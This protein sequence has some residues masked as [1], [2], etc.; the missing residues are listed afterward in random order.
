MIAIK[1]LWWPDDV[2]DKWRHAL[3]HLESIEVGLAHCSAR[4]TAVQ[5]G[6]NIGL[7]P[8]RLSE[9]F[10]RVWTF[11]PDDTSRACLQSNVPAN[12]TVSAQALGAAV[13]QCGLKHKSL[14][15]HRVVDG[16]AIPVTTIDALGLTDLD[17]LQL[18]I[19]GYEWHALAGG[20]DTI[21]RCHPV[22]QLELRGFT[23]K[24]GHSDQAVR[25]LLQALGYS[26]IAQA[27][28]ADVVFGWRAT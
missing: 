5:A 21:A 7:W 28:G 23:E 12:V 27:P 25:E 6:G 11:E 8:R 14:G 1:G 17:F 19:E 4:R 24:Y 10:T 3:R 26:E 15:S 22:I 2:A 13:G 18:D 20:T 16:D 9:T